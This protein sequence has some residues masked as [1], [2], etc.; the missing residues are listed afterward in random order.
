MYNC[1]AYRHYIESRRVH[2]S[3][4][5]HWE[6]FATTLRRQIRCDQLDNDGRR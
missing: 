2:V 6:I 1:A 4:Y 5:C 3:I